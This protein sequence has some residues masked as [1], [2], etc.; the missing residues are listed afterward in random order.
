M[1]ILLNRWRGTGEIFKI[2]KLKIT[3]TI[4]YAIYLG[5]LFGLVTMNVFVGIVTII[6]FLAGESFG[7]GKWVGSLC[8]PLRQKNLQK[9]YDDLEGYNFPWIHKTAN[10]F[11]K[12]RTDYFK[13]CKLALGIRGAWWAFFI[14]LGL[15]GFGFITWYIYLLAILMYAV[16]FP[17]ACYLSTL[18]SFN[19]KSKFISI[20]GEW[21]SQESYYGFIHMVVNILIVCIILL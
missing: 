20:D 19:Y 18:K 8:Y 5:L 4:L 17:L 12:E 14:Y 6:G 16:G 13:Y 9:N 2:N 15:F 10:Y 1:E 3:G 11:V 21:E 7:W